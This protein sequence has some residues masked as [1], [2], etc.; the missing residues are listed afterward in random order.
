V[1]KDLP[2]RPRAGRSAPRRPRVALVLGAGGIT[3]IAWLAGALAALREQT[4]WDPASADLITGTSAGAVAAT[5]LAAGED[6]AGLLRYAEDPDALDDAIARATADREPEGLAVPWPA[7]VGLAL[8]GLVT[9]DRRRASSLAGLI[10]R[11]LRS[12]DEIRGLTHDAAASGWPT[13]TELWLHACDMQTGRLETFGRRGA[14]ESRLADAVVASCAVPGYYRPA[15]IGYRRYVDGGLRSL[16]NADLLAGER[17]D[18]VL[19]LTP[20]STRDRGALLDTAV[21][22]AARAATASRT[23]REAQILREDGASVAVIAPTPDDVRAMGLNPMDRGR[24]RNV[25]ETAAASLSPRFD[26]LLDGIVLPAGAPG[27]TAPAAAA[28]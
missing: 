14:P 12:A 13:R 23:Q 2:R 22:G 8:S 6:P 4:G 25:L 17:C 15:R 20:F 24:S 28:A 19:V 5:V 7:S 18:V 26:A 1:A 10:P 9:R 27:A 21:F 16:S 3:G 11:G